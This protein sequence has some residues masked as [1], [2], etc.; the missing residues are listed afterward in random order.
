MQYGIDA[1][2][3]KL[4][5]AA[6][7][8]TT[9]SVSKQLSSITPTTTPGL[10]A[11]QLAR[12]LQQQAGYTIPGTAGLSLS[13]GASQDI[14]HLGD[15][16]AISG[17][18]WRAMT[19][20]QQ[21]VLMSEGVTGYN[22]KVAS[23]EMQDIMLQNWASTLPEGSQAKI[24][25]DWALSHGNSPAAAAEYA[26]QYASA[27]ASLPNEVTTTTS[28]NAGWQPAPTL[29]SIQKQEQQ[30][31]INQIFT[32]LTTDASGRPK[33]VDL[34]EATRL[35]REA[36]IITQDQRVTGYGGNGFTISGVSTAIQG[37]VPSTVPS[38]IITYYQN[39]P[40][41]INTGEAVDELLNQGYT[42]QQITNAT[43]AYNQLLKSQKQ[44]TALGT[45]EKFIPQISY[46][47]SLQDEITIRQAKGLNVPYYSYTAEALTEFVKANSDYRH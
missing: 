47:E 22:A 9:T 20:E 25:Y 12:I 2:N 19:P 4:Q 7:T 38:E 5:T 1:Y 35:F 3:K 16:S 46:P 33:P 14:I 34:N 26:A 36:G 43:A 21:Q 31:K 41:M 39:N 37:T 23:G 30:N 29:E 24:A 18:D 8:P 15:G 10:S 42:L 40:A 17:A 27:L 28:I 13:S 45:I 44:Q 11:E 6:Q 32:Q